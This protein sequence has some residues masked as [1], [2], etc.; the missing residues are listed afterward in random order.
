MI[1]SLL[2]ILRN[3]LV[4]LIIA[5]LIS[6]FGL[7]FSPF[8]FGNGLPRDPIAVDAIPDIGEN[9]QIVFTE[10]KGRSP[11]DID[12]Q[13]TYPLSSVLLGI[14]GVKTIRSSSMF[15]FSSI[16]VIFEEN[17]EFYWSRSR[18]LEKLNALPPGTLPENVTP[19]LGPDATALGQVFWYTLEGRDEAGNPAPGWDLH[20]LR[21]LQDW[22][23]KTA[24]QSAKGVA[25]VATIGGNSREY[26]IEVYPD[27][28]EAF[29]VSILDL[30]KSVRQANVDIGARTME[31]NQVEYVVRGVGLLK[32]I[33]DIRKIVVAHR[34]DKPIRVADLA[35]VV[36]GPAERRGGLDISGAEAVGGVVVARFGANP[37]EVI[38]AVKEKIDALGISLPRKKLEDGRTSQITIVPV[39]DRSTLINETVQTL[40]DAL[41]QQILITILVVLF[42]LGHLR[43]SIIISASLPLAVMI[44]FIAMKAFSVDANIMSLAGIAIAIGAMVDIGIVITENAVM[45]LGNESDPEKRDQKIAESVA[46]IAPAV[47]TSV[48]T[49]VLSFMPVFAMTAAEGKL[50]SPLA[51]T[52]TFAMIGALIVGFIILPILIQVLL[53]KPSTKYKGVFNVQDFFRVVLS[54][55]IFFVAGIVMVLFGSPALGAV[56]IAVGLLG[57]VITLLGESP[58]ARRIRQVESLI[59]GLIVLIILSHAWLPLS[60]GVSFLTNFFFV[61]VLSLTLLVV[62]WLFNYKYAFL[63][64]WM[65]D[66]KVTFLLVPST[67]VVLAAMTWFGGP[68]LVSWMPQSIRTLAPISKFVHAF[69]GLGSEFM[70]PFDEGEFLYMPT[71]MPHASIGTVSQQIRRIDALLASI[72]EVEEVMG[73]F[74]RAETALDPAPVS[75]FEILIRYKAEWKVDDEGNRVRQ[76]RDHIKSSSDIWDEILKAAQFPGVTSA[77]MLMPINTRIVM[78]QSGMRAPMGIKIKGPTIEANEKA[79]KIIEQELSKVTSVREGTIF[80]ERIVGKPYIEIEID[81]DAIERYGLSLQTVQKTVQL[82]IGG[83]GITQTV[84]GR[85]RHSVRIRY[86]RDARQSPEALLRLHVS[87]PNGEQISLASLASIEYVRGPQV[88]KSENTLLVSYVTFDKIKGAA[89]VAVVEAADAHLKRGIKNGDI[90]LPDGVTYEFAGTFEN[91]V[92]S[93]KRLRYLVPLSIVLIFLLLYLQFNRVSTALMIFTSVAV[94]ASGGMVMLWLYNQSWFLNFSIAGTSMRTLFHVG[95]TNLSVAIWVGFIALIGIATDDGVIMATY[96]KQRFRDFRPESVADIR[97]EVLDAGFRRVRP[98]LMTTA[99]TILALL[100]VM[101]STG[102]GSDIMAPMALPIFGGMVL[103]LI[104]L[105]VVPLLW[106]FREEMKFKMRAKEV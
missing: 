106:S 48:A 94:A 82:A 68:K 35:N 99:T 27:K 102:R 12:D 9:Q 74:G 3:R 75:M 90:V 33:D 88:I 14:P 83:A 21:N 77:P 59:A 52:K 1:N 38:N 8:D 91:Q 81:R 13:I 20:E 73:K 55:P 49:T 5:L 29:N 86:V 87:T 31:I 39:Y 103:E 104:T 45:R 71:T 96:L 67:V 36:M 26:Q 4:V 46:E 61:A 93:A 64:N 25:E 24:L 47:A 57:G 15:G 40:S 28:L 34:N 100:P 43:S 105:F 72:P 7:I 76:W 66:N 18:I 11:R 44:S 60:F 95:P 2:W 54:T 85:E 41:W 32:G 89:E 10:W 63:L 6:S 92:R 101:S 37:I 58:I 65:L 84:E 98:C 70:P 16:Y 17:T 53:L 78:L 23:V 79:G 97:S 80:S 42:L 30:A 22:T 19:A 51:Y 50:F 62:F 56:A 69:P